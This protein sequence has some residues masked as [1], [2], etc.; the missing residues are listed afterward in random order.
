MSLWTRIANVF[1]EAQVNREIDD[2]LEAHVAEA[3]ASGRDAEEARRALGSPLRHREESR[4][5]RLVGWMSDFTQDVRYAL[6]TLGRRPRFAA[7]A[8]LTLALGSGATTVMFT[9]INGVLLRPLPYARPGRLVS[10]QERTE[11]ATHYG[12]LWAFA[13]P[14]FQDCKRESKTLDLAAWRYNVGTASV[15]GQADYASGRQISAGLFSVL[16]VPRAQGRDFLAEE[17]RLG[18][19]PVIILGHRFWQQ[20]FGGNP[21]AIGKPVILD[22]KSFPIVGIAAANFR[23]DGEEPDE[24]TPLGQDNSPSL[25][26]RD[27]HPGISAV[28]RLRPG[29]T[30]KGAR[31]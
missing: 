20:R 3:M 23:L 17:D 9:V 28:A 8:L 31:A 4:D 6:R 25:Q 11:Q 22:G 16:G 1:Q 13:Y 15:D 27:R 29:T 24:F 30:L 5:A 19:E 26:R 2:E 14:N 7:V 18:A 10:L 21:A 12:N